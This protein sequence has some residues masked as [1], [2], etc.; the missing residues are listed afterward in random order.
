LLDEGETTMV[1]RIAVAGLALIG[2]AALVLAA[3]VSGK[4]EGDAGPN[5]EYHL[6]FN[7]KVDGQKLTGT[8]ESPMG[9]SDIANG[10]VN[11][12]ALS[13]EVDTGAGT[14]SYTG[15]AADDS[16][17]LHVVGPWGESDMVIKRTAGGK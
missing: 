6:V 12:D 2:V 8:V 7:F 9:V 13:F 14:I 3:D 11:G 5:G 4:W 17:Q 15:K 10:T 1:K 16:I